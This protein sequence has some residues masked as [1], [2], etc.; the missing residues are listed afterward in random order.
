MAN[1][2]IGEKVINKSG[3]IGSLVSFDDKFIVVDFKT[4]TTK[5]QCNAFEKGF[6]KYEKAD[7]QNKTQESIEQAKIEEKRKVEEKRKAEAKRIAVEKEEVKRYMETSKTCYDVKL[8]KSSIRLESAPVNLNSIPKKYQALIQAI[9]N[10]CDNCTQEL[11]DC[12]KPKMTYPKYTSHSRSKYCVGFLAKYLDVYV[13]RVF[14]RN[15]VYQKRKATGVIVKESDTTEILRVMCLNDQVY[16]FSKNIAY[17]VG[18]YN[19]ST[20]YNK[21]HISDLGRG[22]LLN[23]VIRKC[24]CEYLNDYI[25]ENNIDFNPYSKLLFPALYNNKAE[26]VFKNKLFLS[27]YRIENIIKYLEEF[28]SKQID[29]ASRHNVINALPIIKE[30]GIYDIDILQDMEKLMKKRNGA[31]STYDKLERIF[32]ELNVDS[33]NLGKKLIK[34]LKKVERFDAAVYDDYVQMLSHRNGVVIDDFF[35]KNYIEK[36][37]IM[38]IQNNVFYTREEVE[39]YTRVAKELSWIERED[40]GYFII[41]PKSIAD[42]KCEGEMQHNCVYTNGYGKRVLE[43]NSIIVFLRKVRDIP[44]VTIEFDYETFD[45]LQ[46]YG[47]YNKPIDHDLYQYIVNLGKILNHERFSQ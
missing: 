44:Y 36:H 47:K 12:F 38:V 16:Y 1:I 17:S 39:K 34:F 13:L 14:S 11:Y 24:D 23:E 32:K 43:H 30:Y 40:N 20:G 6:L 10:E 5:L 9:F 46:A 15:D 4:R 21:W 27:V 37:D 26:I 42:L 2:I 31:G 35:D 3:E 7:L 25:E 45:V 22:V 29:F 33:S 18:F 28:T 8:D 19:N 41:I